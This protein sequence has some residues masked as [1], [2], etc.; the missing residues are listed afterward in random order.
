M[1]E[2]NDQVKLNRACLVTVL[3]QQALLRDEQR[4]NEI[5][6]RC[7]EGVF[8]NTLTDVPCN[9]FQSRQRIKTARPVV[10]NKARV[11]LR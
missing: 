11:T 9:L 7:Q 5:Y 10:R 4:S 2:V 1:R 8:K 6:M 3:W